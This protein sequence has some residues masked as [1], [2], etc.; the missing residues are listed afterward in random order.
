MDKNFEKTGITEKFKRDIQ[1]QKTSKRNTYSDNFK[2]QVIQEYLNGTSRKEILS[3]YDI[4]SSTL[5]KWIQSIKAVPEDT[6]NA[7]NT[8]DDPMQKLLLENE[9][10]KKVILM[11]LDI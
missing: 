11:L 6:D 4:S 8:E 9:M 3:K 5:Y 7:D 2:V 1:Q 10:L